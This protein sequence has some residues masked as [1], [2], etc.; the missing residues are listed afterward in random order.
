MIRLHLLGF[1]PDLKGLVFSARRGGRAGTYWV[2]V[3]PELVS[4]LGSLEAAREEAAVSRRSRAAAPAGRGRGAARTQAAAKSRGRAGRALVAVPQAPAVESRLSPRE[5]QQ[6]LREGR[7]VKDV[8]ALAGVDTSWVERFLGPIEEERTGIIR[9]T[10]QSF[11]SRTRLG[12]SGLPIGEAVAR[13]LTER[14]ATPAT[15]DS[16]DEGWD[17]RR[18]GPRIWRVRLRFTHRGKR[19]SAEWEFRTDDRSVRPRNELA[20]GLGWAPPRQD[21][22]RPRVPDM[23]PSPDVAEAPGQAAA[24]RPRRKAPAKARPKPRT[25]SK[26]KTTPKPKAR[27]KPKTRAAR[28]RARLSRS[29]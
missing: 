14:R 10:K 12:R 29:R 11:Q 23:A 28:S 27:G 20:S 6:L 16:L 7:A 26:P 24:A 25:R 8:A 21:R 15:L 4:A 9:T 13:N 1:T 17:T 3:D 2:A 19:R 5:V 22:G 18:T